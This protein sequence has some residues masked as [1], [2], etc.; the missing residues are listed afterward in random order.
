MTTDFA[1]RQAGILELM[2]EPMLE[3]HLT[4]Q[5]APTSSDAGASL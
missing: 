2:L 4:S 5:E 3:G 1:E